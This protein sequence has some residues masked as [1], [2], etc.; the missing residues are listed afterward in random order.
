MPIR[1]GYCLSSEDRRELVAVAQRAESIGF[2]TVLVSDH[3]G[4]GDAPMITLATAAQATDRIRLGTFVLNNDM[5]NPVQLAWE[6]ATLDRLSGGRFELGLGAGH[7]PQEYTATGI[8]LRS[9]SE[10][11]QRLCETVEVMGALLAGES[12]TF[13]GAF[14]H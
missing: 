6:A 14:L 10:R 9:A 5:R 11:K 4:G 3:V 2:D 7:T 12:V 13:H 1:F 8:E